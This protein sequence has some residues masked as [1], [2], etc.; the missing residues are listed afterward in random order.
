MSLID[1][2]LSLSSL[3]PLHW[4]GIL[5]ALISAVIHLV[6]GVSFLPHWMGFTFLLA[7]GGFLG[8][9]VLLLVGFRRRLL[10]L[11]GIPYTAVQIVGWYVVNQPA[12]VADLTASG[13]I[14]KVAQLVLIVVVV[15]LYRR[16][17]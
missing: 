11:V 8:G 16:E 4:L 17:S 13:V 9:I 12:G 10:Y 5:M 1:S 2:R 3:T 15:V 7:A 6:L 14:D